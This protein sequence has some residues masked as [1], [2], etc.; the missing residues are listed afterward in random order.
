MNTRFITFERR[1][2]M[3]IYVGNLP[4]D[5]TEADLRGLFSDYGAVT[6]VALITDRETGRSR[7]FGFVELA[8]DTLGRKAVDELAGQDWNGRSLTVNEARPRS[9]RS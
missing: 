9:S 1:V 7:G 4:F 5:V 6:S 3:N 8:D 2:A